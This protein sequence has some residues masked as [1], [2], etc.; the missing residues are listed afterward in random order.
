MGGKTVKG[1]YSKG[2][3]CPRPKWLHSVIHISTPLSMAKVRRRC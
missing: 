1:P 3:G 2:L